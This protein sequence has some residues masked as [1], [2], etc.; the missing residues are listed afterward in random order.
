MFFGEKHFESQKFLVILA[1]RKNEH[2]NKALASVFFESNCKGSFV[3]SEKAL[4]EA[5]FYLYRLFCRAIFFF[6]PHY[7]DNVAIETGKL[8]KSDGQRSYGGEKVRK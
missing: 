8:R 2:A 7:A 3:T 1:V 6:M 4:L 5:L